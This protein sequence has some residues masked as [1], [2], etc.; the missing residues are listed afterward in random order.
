MGLR[1]VL[2]LLLRVG[3][4]ED[5]YPVHYGTVLFAR[6][7]GRWLGCIIVIEHTIP[8]AATRYQSV[9]AHLGDRTGSDGAS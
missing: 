4:R 2:W 7:S 3:P 1:R 6:W 5:V 8:G 9:Y